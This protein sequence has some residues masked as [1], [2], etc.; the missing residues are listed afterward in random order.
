VRASAS[1]TAI[2]PCPIG[3]RAN[4][5]RG[6]TAHSGRRPHRTSDQRVTPN[7]SSGGPPADCCAF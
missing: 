5:G 2:S 4:S 7:Q 6:P 1:V 3:R